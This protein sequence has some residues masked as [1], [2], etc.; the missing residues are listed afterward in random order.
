M[1]N[2][3]KESLWNRFS[4]FSWANTKVTLVSHGGVDYI[5]HIN[6]VILGT[7]PNYKTENRSTYSSERSRIIKVTRWVEYIFIQWPWTESFH[8]STQCNNPCKLCI[9]KTLPRWNSS[10]L[11]W[12]NVANMQLWGLSPTTEIT[13]HCS[14]TVFRDA[15]D[16]AEPPS[17]M[18]RMTNPHVPLERRNL[19]YILRSCRR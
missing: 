17:E 13:H 12:Q 10:A 7:Y 8:T 15:R 18:L 1:V 4:C 9:P 6:L 16:D 14:F 5:W 19:R 3:M 2:N 11:P